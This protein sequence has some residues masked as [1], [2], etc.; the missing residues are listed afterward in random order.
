MDTQRT[1]SVFLGIIAI[2]GSVAALKLAS[3]VMMPIFFSLL[4]SFTLSPVVD[5]L[6]RVKVPRGISIVLAILILCGIGYL[7][8]L[9]LLSSLQS[10]IEEWPKYYARF[11]SILQQISGALNTNFQMDL[12]ENPMSE[13]DLTATFI[14]SI[15]TLSANFMSFFKGLVIVILSTIFLLLDSPY[16][17]N[18]IAKAFPR[19]TG[20]RIVI[21]MRHTIR[22]IGR[23]LSVKFLVSALTGVLVWFFL[24]IIGMDFALIWGVMA[25][26]LNFIPNIGSFILMVV[27]IL[28]GFIQF[29]PLPGRIIAVAFSMIGVQL[30]VGNFLDPRIQGRRLNLSPVI[31]IFSL[32][33]WGWIW[34]PVGMFIAVPIT[35]VIKIVCQNIPVLKPLSIMMEN[36]RKVGKGRG[37]W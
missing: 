10:F 2:L 21:I 18:T 22:Q 8:G 23:Y 32:F 37:W 26:I 12:P 6:T 30:V 35:A 3:S 4:L 34:G 16:L 11:E 13:I 36:G 29:F 17:Q 27:T 19:H 20:K 28:M 24:L 25:F 33:L 7:V 9:F 5:G 14:G 15:D 1:N 31:I